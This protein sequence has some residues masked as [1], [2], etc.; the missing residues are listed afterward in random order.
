MKEILY[1]QA[2]EFSNYTGTH[3]WNTQESYLALNEDYTD[4]DSGVSFCENV[5]DKVSARY[6]I[7]SS[8]HTSLALSLIGQAHIMSSLD[9]NR[10]Q[11]QVSA[12]YSTVNGYN[13]CQTSANFGTLAG[14][15]ALGNMGEVPEELTESLWCDITTSAAGYPF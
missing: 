7:Q 8:F 10:Q 12:W 14:C 9:F 13:L 5:D 2:G 11:M 15:N 1:I 6:L 4:I 3:F